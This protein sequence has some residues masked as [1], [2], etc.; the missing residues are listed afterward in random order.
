MTHGPVPAPVPQMVQLLKLSA[1]IDGPAT[2][3][4]L[5]SPLP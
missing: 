4:R 5:V 1:S 2:Y 3:M